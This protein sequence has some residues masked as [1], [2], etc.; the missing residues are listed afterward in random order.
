[1][2][3]LALLLLACSLVLVTAMSVAVFGGFVPTSDR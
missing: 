3:P 1:M 2:D